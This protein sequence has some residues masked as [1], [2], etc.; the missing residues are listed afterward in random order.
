MLPATV[1]AVLLAASDEDAAVQE[2][3][4]GVNRVLMGLARLMAQGGVREEDDSAGTGAGTGEGKGS[5]RGGGGSVVG[6]AAAGGNA[7]KHDLSALSQEL[8]E[9]EEVDRGDGTLI[10]PSGGGQLSPTDVRMLVE[11]VTKYVSSDSKLCR[12]WSLAWLLLLLELHPG[13]VMASVD[14]VSRPLLANVSNESISEGEL[15][16]HLEVLGAMCKVDPDA[17]RGRMLRSVLEQLRNRERLRETRGA[18]IL[19][20]LCDLLDSRATYVTLARLLRGAVD[21]AEDSSA[22]IA[23]SA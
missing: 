13:H 15:G 11:M 2:E 21:D 6:S 4:Q 8:V 3:A 7:T 5:T 12:A 9:V 19:R 1:K 16:S 22:D 23:R 20:H 10:D 18:K 14:A 17:F